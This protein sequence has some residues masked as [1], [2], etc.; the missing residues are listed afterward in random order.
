[1]SDDNK[2][3]EK[4]YDR[5][6]YIY[7]LIEKP[8]EIM[9]M[10]KYRKQIIEKIEGPKVLEI[11]VGTGKNLGYYPESLEV[12][13]IDF[14]KKML[15]QANQKIQDK[16]HI[17]LI[18]MDAQNMEFKDNTFD[19]V[20][21]SCVFCSVPDPI[22]GLKE[23]RRVCKKNGKIVMLEHMRSQNKVVGKFMDVINFIPLGICGANINRKTMENLKKAGFNEKDIK[24]DNI[25]RDIVKLIEIRN[26]K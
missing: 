17:K 25:W 5:I 16:S 9:A 3:I 4:R 15:N 14:S 26:N 12:I 7:D 23:M 22:K 21:T 24:D 6:S 19:T 8:M 10:K 2:K 11:G 20:I 18:E 1:M 13:G